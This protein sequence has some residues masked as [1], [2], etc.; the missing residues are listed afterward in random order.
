M[1]LILVQEVSGVG[2]RD[3]VREVAAGYALNFLLPHGLAVRATPEKLAALAQRNQA[4]EQAGSRELE[5]AK[6]WGNELRG[7]SVTII[8]RASKNGTLYAAI[9]ASAVAQAITTQLKVPVTVS[10]V[11]LSE[12]LKAVGNHQITLKFHD[13]I[14]TTTTTLTLIIKAATNAKD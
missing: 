8:A 3:E 13:T 6:A 7:K 11:V 10:Q 5:R 9:P 12:H 14:T 1:K 2:H 4:R